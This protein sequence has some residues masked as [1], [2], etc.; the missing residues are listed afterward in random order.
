[1]SSRISRQVPRHEDEKAEDEDE[2]MRRKQSARRNARRHSHRTKPAVVVSPPVTHSASFGF[3][4][5][6]PLSLIRASTAH[7]HIF[8][9]D[10]LT[11]LH[12]RY[13]LPLVVMSYVLLRRRARAVQCGMT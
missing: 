1:M 3:L 7:S 9:L 10:D 4:H 11:L 5:H 13:A 2:E 12:M 6:G 8:L